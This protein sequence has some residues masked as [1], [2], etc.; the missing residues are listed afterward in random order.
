MSKLAT[1]YPRDEVAAC[2][3]QAL[4]IVS[5]Y[6]E[7]IFPKVAEESQSPNDPTDP[8]NLAQGMSLWAAEQ[9]L[10]VGLITL[11]HQWERATGQLLNEQSSRW[12]IP[13]KARSKRSFNSWVQAVLLD[14]F[15]ASIPGEVWNGLEELR[16]L[17]NVLKHADLASFTEFAADYPHYFLFS[18]QPIREEDFENNFLVRRDHFNALASSVTDF[19]GKLPYA[20]KY[21]AA[22]ASSG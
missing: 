18:S 11:Y 9:V 7:Y 6:G 21:G 8:L 5:L 22:S 12:G 19:W 2:Q 16:R 3:I 15:D 17:V 10:R 20:V 14:S 1:F 4:H 13:M